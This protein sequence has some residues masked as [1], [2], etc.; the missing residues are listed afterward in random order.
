MT[1][2]VDEC[3]N[4]IAFFDPHP[5]LTR[6][7]SHSHIKYPIQDQCQS[8]SILVHFFSNTG[9][10]GLFSYIFSDKIFTLKPNRGIV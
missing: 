1:L 5:N 7:L 4:S 3:V 2:A 8:N 10:T 9:L 6:R